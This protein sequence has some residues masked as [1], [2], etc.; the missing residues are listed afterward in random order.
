[1]GE[2]LFGASERMIHD[3][4]PARLHELKTQRHDLHLEVV[5]AQPPGI[6]L[7]QA[8]GGFFCRA[9][10]QSQRDLARKP[11]CKVNNLR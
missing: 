11:H 5:K 6:D 4:P 10:Q 3:A 9:A 8:C 1:V 7:Y 2:D